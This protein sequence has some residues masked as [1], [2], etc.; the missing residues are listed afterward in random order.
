MDSQR[1]EQQ[2][3]FILEADKEKSI[4]RQTLLSNGKAHENDADH[5]WHMALMCLLLSEYANE[6]IDVLR[7]VGMILIHDIVEIDAGDTYAYDEQ[8]L[9]TQRERELKAA[10]RLYSLLPPD[11]A[12]KLRGWWDEF[13]EG[14][15]PEARFARALD[16]VQPAMLNSAT[17]G[18]MWRRNG[19]KL[20]QILN[21]NKNTADGSAVL[22]DYAFEHFIRPH[23]EKGNILDNL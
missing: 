16:N 2:F 15:T 17:D 9:T 4:M 21:R 19:V 23:V 13:E 18:E 3:A 12:A 1:L 14:K 7:T 8:G 22:W 20:S 10:D 6:K 5:A 11:Q